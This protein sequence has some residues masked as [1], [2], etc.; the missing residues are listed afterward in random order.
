MKLVENALLKSLD[1]AGLIDDYARGLRDAAA[2]LD[3]D[4]QALRLH[5]GELSAQE[6][7]AVLAVLRWKRREI[8]A[9]AG[10]R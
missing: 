7:R 2:T 4:R 1:M 5:A 9:R 10:N 8:M 3:V 6:M